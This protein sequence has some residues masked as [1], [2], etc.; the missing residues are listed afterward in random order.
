MKKTIGIIAMFLGALSVIGCTKENPVAKE[1]VLSSES[2]V[3]DYTASDKSVAVTFSVDG[4]SVSSV[5][6]GD[7]WCTAEIVDNTIKVAVEENNTAETRSTV[8]TVSFNDAAL[9]E[10]TIE[11]AQEAGTPKSL[12][13]TAVE[14][15]KYNCRGGEYRFT[16]KS[17]D[18]WTAEIVDCDWAVLTSSKTVGTVTVTASPNDG[19]AERA[20][21]V[22]VSDGTT[23][24]EYSFS[25]EC[26]AQDE[27]LSLLGEYDIYATQWYSI[28]V[29]SSRGYCNSLAY[30]GTL[31]DLKNSNFSYYEGTPFMRTTTLVEDKYGKS[32]LLKDFL[33]KGVSVPV[34]Y[35]AATGS[36]TIPAMWNCG[37][38]YDSANKVTSPCFLVGYWIQSNAIYFNRNSSGLFKCEV[39]EDKNTITIT[40]GLNTEVDETTGIKPGSGL[41]MVYMDM[42]LGSP[43]LTPFNY[44]CIPFGDNVQLKRI[45]PE[46]PG[47]E[48]PGAGD[49]GSTEAE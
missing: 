37:F 30:D 6:A 29:R 39:S 18:E 38:I 32:Y 28:S 43:T 11:V 27:Y 8:V 16:V 49:A 9:S 26:E 20:G 23:T 40:T 45:L 10:K 3:F 31:R 15:Y 22:K 19:D 17:S 13:T 41:T 36:V 42:S 24:L 14:N 48:E 5:V 33:I 21:K 35:D 4:L 46:N 47:T 2:L 1:A 12:T 34:N 7:T 44:S 25:Q